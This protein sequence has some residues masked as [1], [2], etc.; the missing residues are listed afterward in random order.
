[1]SNPYREEIIAKMLFD[2]KNELNSLSDREL[3]L[4]LKA[5]NDTLA[6]T[7]K[8]WLELINKFMGAQ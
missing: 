8:E 1:M 4:H 7:D 2:Y 3:E 5:M 6:I